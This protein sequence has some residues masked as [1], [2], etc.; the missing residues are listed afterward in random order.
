[1]PALQPLTVT[2][3]DA[4]GAIQRISRALNGDRPRVLRGETLGL[5][6]MEALGHTG[7]P[8]RKVTIEAEVGKVVAVTIEMDGDERLLGI[9]RPLVDA[10]PRV[11]RR[12]SPWRPT[13]ALERLA[14]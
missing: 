1:M 13:L 10:D 11:S 12:G 5:A 14:S 8:W 2:L 3:A 7:E 9:T 6:V 4:T